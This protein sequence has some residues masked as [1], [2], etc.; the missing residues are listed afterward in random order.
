MVFYW[1]RKS[2][3]WARWMQFIGQSIDLK[4]KQIH[5]R[6]QIMIYSK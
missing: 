4:K 1:K 2:I 5:I 6:I 3:E